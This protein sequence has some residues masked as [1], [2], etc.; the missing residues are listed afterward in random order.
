MAM[1]SVFC[2]GFFDSWLLGLYRLLI[3]V[4]PKKKH[5]LPLAR[6]NN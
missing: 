5:F 3:V 2:F 4:S 6:A 1:V